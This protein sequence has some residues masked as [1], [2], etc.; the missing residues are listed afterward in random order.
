MDFYP[1]SWLA[2]V[3]I[4]I[5]R[6]QKAKFSLLATDK[7][8][9]CCKTVAGK[10]SKTGLKVATVAPM[11]LYWRGQKHGFFTNF[12]RLLHDKLQTLSISRAQV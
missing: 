12:E 9:N 4:R 5:S 1:P 7:P 10:R 11:Q 3:Q 6:P 8:K 2:R